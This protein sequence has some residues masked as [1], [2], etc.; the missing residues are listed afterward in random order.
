MFFW[1]K[2]K[3]E[4]I[5]I[6]SF[7]KTLVMALV[8]R[9]RTPLNGARWVLEPMIKDSKDIDEQLLKES[10]NKIIEAIN[11]TTEVLNLM[12]DGKKAEL[13][14]EEFDLC[15][16]IDNILNNLKYIAKEKNNTLEYN[17][18]DYSIVFA[19][20]DTLELALTNV[21]DNAFRYSSHSKVFVSIVREDGILKLIVKDNGVGIAPE[22]LKNIFDGFLSSEY[23]MNMEPGKNGIGLY[24]T[25]KILEMNGGSIKIDSVL[26][27]GTTVEIM[28]PI[29]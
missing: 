14:K 20:R 5:K 1:K 16:L 9:L 22:K 18:C 12:S 6:C 23:R 2:N 25:K 28:L 8:H 26:G 10:Y 13:K 19:D 17:K 11:I 29:K 15:V 7:D 3:K 4:E 21:I 24:T 27:E